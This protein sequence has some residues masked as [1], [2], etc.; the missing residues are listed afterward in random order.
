M[1]NILT[2]SRPFV[3]IADKLDWLAL[4]IARL[5]TALIF[6]P[7]GWHKLHGLQ[8]LSDW[9]GTLGIPFPYANAVFVSSLEW[10][11]GIGL[12]LGLGTRF[13]SV[14]LIG[15]MAVALI[16]V[17]PQSNPP[18]ETLSDWAFKAESILIFVFLIFMTHGPGKA[19]IDHLIRN[20]LGWGAR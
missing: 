2:L 13:F 18:P 20:K 1:L 9:F 7:G 15:V 11:G 4:L 12:V 6:V 14:M 5:G 17:G 8:G 16:T 19:S 3:L 10:V